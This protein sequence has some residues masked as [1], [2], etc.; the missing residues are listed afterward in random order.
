MGSLRYGSK[1]LSQ[2]NVIFVTQTIPL[3]R[4]VLLICEA[5]NWKKT[6]GDFFVITST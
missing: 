5:Y 1:S 2:H 3:A 4:M 6:P